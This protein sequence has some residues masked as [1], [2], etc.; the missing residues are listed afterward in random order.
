MALSEEQRRKINSNSAR[1]NANSDTSD[2]SDYQEFLQY[3]EMKRQQ[4]LQKQEAARQAELQ[5]EAEYQLQQ[6]E[7]RRQ[8]EDIQRQQ[9]ELQQA[10]AQQQWQQQQWQQQQF[11]QQQN[12]YVNGSVPNGNVQQSSKKKNFDDLTLTQKLAGWA[13]FL[14]LVLVVYI[15]Q[16]RISFTGNRTNSSL[17]TSRTT[18]VTEQVQNNGSEVNNESVQEQQPVVKNNNSYLSV[19]DTANVN[20]FQV[21]LLDAFFV[22][23]NGS[24]W[25]QASDGKQY[26]MLEFEGVNTSSDDKYA[27][28]ADFAAYCDDYSVDVSIVSGALVDGKTLWGGDVASGKKIRGV[29]CYELPTDFQK[30]EIRVSDSMWSSK[31]VEF[32]VMNPNR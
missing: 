32:V 17:E 27:S 16:G 25:A 26:F 28:L 8:Q 2:M 21:T 13:I 20:G 23:P 7:L 12:A 4:E 31:Y 15:V 3:K 6:E 19:G 14:A 29:V 5:R 1:R 18:S 30:F 22:D 10:Q 11:A 9:I 24:I